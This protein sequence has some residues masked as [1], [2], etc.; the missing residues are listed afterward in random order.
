MAAAVPAYCSANARRRDLPQ[1]RAVDL[2]RGTGV[3]CAGRP[4]LHRP[5]QPDRDG[6]GVTI[7]GGCRSP[8]TAPSSYSSHRSLRLRPATAEGRAWAGP[9][10]RPGWIHRA[11]G[12][13]RL[14][15]GH[16][17]VA[18][19]RQPDQPRRQ[20][21]ARQHPVRFV[22]DFA[23]WRRPAQVVSDSRDGD[24]TLHRSDIRNAGASRHAWT[25]A[26]APARTDDDTPP[27]TWPTAGVCQRPR[28][29]RPA[30]YGRW[31]NVLI[32]DAGPLKWA[33]AGIRKISTMDGHSSA[34]PG[35]DALVAPSASAASRS[36]GTAPPRR[37]Q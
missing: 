22:P 26:P 14:G 31:H 24:E 1:H 15:I 36:A 28:Q 19:G 30:A 13:Q 25:A 2:H 9:G 32:S 8:A 16:R 20:R 6:T 21:G 17:C 18:S 34:T 10:E 4:C 23:V 5:L 12:N 3:V 37:R 35:F 33:R 29:G 7:S 11:G 27:L